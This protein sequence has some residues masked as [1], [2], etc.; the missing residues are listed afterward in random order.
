[1][2]P[3]P[4]VFLIDDDTDDQ[5][6]FSIALEQAHDNAQCIF[7]N[8]GIHALEKINSDHT[9]V[10]DFIFIDMNM[11]RMNGQQCLQEIKKINRLRN[12]P[13]FML[14]TSMDSASMDEHKKL[15]A[16]DFIVKP[17]DINSLT[18]ML[19]K[20]LRARM[21][22]MA[23]VLYCLSM[24][25]VKSLA[26]D[27]SQVGNLKN[28]SVEKLFNIEV[29]SVSRTPQ[30]IKEVASAIQVVSGEEIRRSSAVRITGA[31]R[32]APNLQVMQAG[33]HDWGIS[34]RGFNGVPVSNSSLANK[35]LVL[36]DGRT[37]YTPLF[38]GVFWDVQNVML[39]DIDQVEVITGPGG[40]LWGANAVNGIINIKSKTARETQGIYA[41]AAYGSLL[42]DHGAV[43]YGGQIDSTFFFRVYG[44]R[45]DYNSS[46]SMI[47]DNY[48]DEWYMN[49]GGFR[50]DYF[51]SAKNIITLQGDLYHGVEDDTL[52]TRV[53]GQYLLSRWTHTFSPRSET[54]LQLY[55][56]RADRNITRQQF[57]AIVNTYD[58]DFQHNLSLG[59][60]HKF[61]WGLGYRVADDELTFVNNDF[62]PASKTQSLWNG[63]AQDIFM[64]VPEKL[65][66]TVGSKILHNDY[67]GIEFHPTIRLLYNM[68]PSQTLWTSASRAVRTPTRFDS[69]NNGV[70]LGSYGEFKSEKVNA[71]ELGYRVR[72]LYNLSFSLAC[73]YN[74]YTDLRSIDTNFTGPPYYYFDNNLE[75]DAWGG[76]ISFN[77]TPTPWWKLRG[78][79]TYMDKDFTYLSTNTYVDSDEFDAIDPKNMLLLHSMM[80]VMKHFQIDM[81]F[82]YVDALPK[83]LSLP[84]VNSYIN[85]D[86]R[87]AYTY[88]WATLSVVGQ[89][90]AENN[91]NE[92][93]QRE[94][95]RSIYGK[96]SVNF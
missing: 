71:Y 74:K 63:F 35:L 76:E 48:R 64:L 85:L 94:I 53:N 58:L 54:T 92:F 3:N 67:T 45:F 70:V 28:L 27:S 18:N 39:E 56:D 25:P 82:R 12:V 22:T 51:P 81:I 7:A 90:L 34:A 50:M 83:A 26:Q 4:T 46:H 73:Y 52:S 69:D 79:Y 55:Y 2:H 41:T 61:V 62:V 9:L 17:S 33:S 6:I 86:V 37:V 75:A 84:R 23:I 78:G 29:T 88:K 30:K 89:N 19:A 77:Y 66:L 95:P 96:I 15:G 8:D 24:I 49:Q 57:T 43:R 1:M 42:Q 10:P 40:A 11:P 68:T 80:D 87:L 93:G 31:L 72:P 13:V 59:Q 47:A 91:T 21:M 5:E 20:I 38:G 32:L 60:H 65:E 14:S 36:I 16:V 44:Q